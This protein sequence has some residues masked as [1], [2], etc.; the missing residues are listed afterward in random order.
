MVSYIVINNIF[1]SFEISG[2]LVQSFKE[3]FE[4]NKQIWQ[5]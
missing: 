5:I 3:Y 4:T 1:V 2:G